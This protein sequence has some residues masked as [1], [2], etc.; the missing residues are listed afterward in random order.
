MSMCGPESGQYWLDRPVLQGYNLTLISSKCP[1]SWCDH[2]WESYNHCFVDAVKLL[3]CGNVCASLDEWHQSRFIASPYTPTDLQV[4]ILLN[5]CIT[6]SLARPS[7]D[8]LE[9]LELLCPLS[10]LYPEW[11]GSV[12]AHPESLS[13]ASMLSLTEAEP[14]S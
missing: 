12:F 14:S 8:H 6:T 11:R 2:R 10:A 7:M 9:D 13:M 4:S 3:S 1:V 5:P